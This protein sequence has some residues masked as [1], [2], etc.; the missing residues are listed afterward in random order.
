MNE[1]FI[2]K[3]TKV[4]MVCLGLSQLKKLPENLKRRQFIQSKYNKELSSIE[5]IQLP[6]FSYTVQHYVIKVPPDLRNKLIDYF[7]SV[8]TAN[9]TKL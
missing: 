6:P 9:N 5:K 8:L 1:F 7:D 3:C 2:Y 4:E